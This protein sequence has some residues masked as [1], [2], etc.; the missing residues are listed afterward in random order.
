MVANGF[1]GVPWF[2]GG[3]A[4]HSAEIARLAAV[5][6]GSG[7]VEGV[8]GPNDLKVVPTSGTANGQVHVNLGACSVLNR[9]ANA[10]SQKYIC[11]ETQV[12]DLTI[13][14]T[15][16]SG[17]SDLIVVSVEDPQYPP[18]STS[19]WSQSQIENG[20]YVFPR[21]IS[22]V[23][24]TTKRMADLASFAGGIYV[25]RSMLALAR[26]DIP[27]G[28]SAI[29]AGMIK[30]LRKLQSPHSEA[31]YSQQVGTAWGETLGTGATSWTNWPN[32]SLSVDIPTWA[33]HAFITITL[34]TVATDGVASDFNP[35]ISLGSLTSQSAAWDYNGS[36]PG[37]TGGNKLPFPMFAEFDVTSLQGQTV[38]LR[39]QAQRTFVTNAGLVQFDPNSQ[40][41]FDVRFFEKVL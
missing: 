20:P 22:G 11:R 23:P 15:G 7:M 21:V 39:P 6:G 17:R 24:N 8:A 29:T 34:N 40:I 28:T 30:D 36:P 5:L 27:S 2:I 14:S 25:N 3:G 38:T 1:E 4:K 26:I 31:V 12:S 33:T 35:R 41:I 13:T 16:G 19:G 32:N 10:L 37:A 18:F 9:S